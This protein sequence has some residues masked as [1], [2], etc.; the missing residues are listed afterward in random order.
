MDSVSQGSIR[1]PSSTCSL[2]AEHGLVRLMVDELSAM[3]MI[4]N[5]ITPGYIATDNPLHCA[6]TS[7]AAPVS[8]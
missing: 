1:V 6:P 8:K 7:S 3:G 4:T 5:A 2:S